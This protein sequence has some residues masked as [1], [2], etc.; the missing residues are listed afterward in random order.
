M[1]ISQ[2]QSL[3]Q[4]TNVFGLGKMPK[5]QNEDPVAKHSGIKVLADTKQDYIYPSTYEN[6]VDLLLKCRKATHLKTA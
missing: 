4:G 1:P 2:Y 5:I 6:A 3:K